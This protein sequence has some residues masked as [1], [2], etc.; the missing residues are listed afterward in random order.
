[1]QTLGRY[2]ALT[3]WDRLTSCIKRVVD[4]RIYPIKSCKGFSV[5]KARI[6]ARGFIY[7]RLFMVVD[8]DGKFI[9]Q[10]TSPELALVETAIKGDDLFI[11]APNMPMVAFP[12][13]EPPHVP[14]ERVKVWSDECD[15]VEVRADVSAWFSEYLKI[16]GCKLVRMKDGFERQTHRKYSPS[17]QTG[18]ADMFP[19]LMISVASLIDLNHRLKEPIKMANFRPNIIVD[20]VDK[21]EEDTWKEV[22]AGGLRLSVVKACSRCKMPNVVPELGVMDTSYPVTSVLNTYRTGADLNFDKS[23][24]NTVFFGMQLDNHNVA[25][26]VVCVGDVLA[27]K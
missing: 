19:F 23:V 26:G 9:S 6:T 17:G 4:L 15:A 14:V 2:N 3:W 22:V 21:F 18:F 24:A 10:R 7:D 13:H 20:G 8:E 5:T 1:M 16:K 25:G 11:S 27:T 12:L